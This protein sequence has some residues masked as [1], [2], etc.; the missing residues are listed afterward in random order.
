MYIQ[1]TLEDYIG[2]H[3]SIRFGKIL[4]DLDAL[5]GSISYVHCD[6]GRNDTP[7]LTI[8]TASVDRIDLLK[9]IPRHEDISISGFVTCKS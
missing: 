2:A 9:S 8:V 7:P 3:G 1:Q 6:D 5:A 4:E